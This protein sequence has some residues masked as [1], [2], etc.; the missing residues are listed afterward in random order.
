MTNQP[1][2]SL[3]PYDERLRALG[4]Q[5][6]Q[7]FLALVRVGRSYE[8][9]NQVFRFQ[10][11][12]FL[13]AI[14]PVFDDAE[15]A[16]LVAL[17]SDLYLNGV[18]IPVRNQTF[19]SHELLREEFERR[20]IAGLRVTPEVCEED[21]QRFFALFLRPGDYHGT[22]LLETCL[23]EGLNAI[24]PA[25]HA[26]TSLPEAAGAGMAGFADTDIARPV[27][28]SHDY[29]DEAHESGPPTAPGEAGSAPRGSAPKSFHAA[30]AGA[31]SLLMTTA[32]NDSIEIRHAKRV[33]QPLVDGAF[34][35][36]P[37]VMGLSS[38]G[39]HDEYTYMH[40]VNVGMVAVTVGHFLG[41]DRRLLADL[42]VAALLHDVGKSA[43][44]DQ[45][46]HPLGEWSPEERAAAERHTLEGARQI[47]RSTVLNGTT[48]RCMR[49][50]LEHHSGPGGYPRLD[51]WTPSVLSQIVA[52]SDCYVSLLS[53][54]SDRGQGVTPNQAIAMMLGPL[55]SR[56][57]PALLWALVKSVGLFPPGQMVEL[58]DGSKAVVLA[59]NPEDLLRPH[60]R[61]V[62]SPEG[63]WLVES[64][65]VDHRPLKEALHIRYAL[66]AEDYPMP[67]ESRAA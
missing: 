57:E 37:V 14:R 60:V 19:K 62:T 67:P 32:L 44:A 49:V 48:L 63:E 40:A 33:V 34:A 21:V 7:R 51:D 22:G 43:V 55:A 56:F 29:D 25:V 27:T 8:V 35:N 46:R 31:R 36:E 16:V 58:S 28:F 3:R 47:A 61:V 50:A 12:H 42:G 26:T 20:R 39:H 53:H 30:V 65:R 5:I 24:Q 38:M 45:V 52:V 15:E 17:E 64:R 18:R 1:P 41:L 10:L 4:D 11:Q 9:G 6:V 66:R 13:D 59:P 54:R 23:A 2:G